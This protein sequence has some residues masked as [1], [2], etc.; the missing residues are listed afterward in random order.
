[1]VS[2]CELSPAASAFSAI[3]SAFVGSAVNG[4][5]NGWLV[6]FMTGWIAWLALLRVLV[7]GSYM[8]YTSITDRW[9]PGKRPGKGDN[10]VDEGVGV[11][12]TQ[13]AIGAYY[14]HPHQQTT[15]DRSTSHLVAPP[16]DHSDGNAYAPGWQ[17]VPSGNNNNQPPHTNVVV[18]KV[19]VRQF[20]ANIW[21][22]PSIVRGTEQPP[23]GPS[24]L[25][26]AGKDRRFPL[27]PQN[28]LN[29]TVTAL[30]WISLFYTAL[31]APLTQ[32]LFLA[33][34]ASRHSNGAAKLVKGLTVAV[35]ALP[36]CIDCRARYADRLG[37]GW[38]RYALNLFLATSCLLQGCICATL[39]VTGLL[40]TKNHGSGG[41]GS[42]GGK[43]KS[44]SSFSNSK[45]SEKHDGGVP[46]PVL[47]GVYIFFST[48]WMV[49]SFLLLPMRD[50]GRKGAGKSHWA[51]Y[52]ID[53]FVGLFAGVFLAAPAFVLYSDATFGQDGTSGLGD[54]GEYLSCEGEPI[55][56]RISAVLP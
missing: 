28:D 33:A 19:T 42:S 46:A 17:P 11:D 6:A 36:L 49:A 24:G 2:S 27:T 1:M 26:P 20:L 30:G 4:I 29:R 22:P 7:G 44:S 51:G 18:R 12:D 25:G 35:T 13:I 16:A 10:D 3:L 21:P 52:L 23:I 48:I 31:Y 37:R 38:L 39:L 5:A 15:S 47:I 32:I 41:S 53:L 14:H 56:R 8:F 45:F 50:G 54:L 43:S 55:W 9:G 40:D 34:N